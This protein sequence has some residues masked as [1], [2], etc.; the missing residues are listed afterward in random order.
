M[1]SNDKV[2]EL[3]SYFDDLV[4]TL[5]ENESYWRKCFPCKNN[6]N[7]CVESITAA[8]SSEWAIIRE[9][10]SRLPEVDLLTLKRNISNNIRCP[11]RGEN[12]C[13][14][15][16]V[17][18]IVCRV[19]P[20]TIFP[21]SNIIDFSFSSNKCMKTDIYK[22]SAE[23][24]PICLQDDLILL[25]VIP[26]PKKVYFIN[27]NKL[28]SHPICKKLRAEKSRTVFDWLSDYIERDINIP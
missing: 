4:N 7:C 23:F 5:L 14:I 27:G 22:I 24:N 28:F 6:G 21:K 17:R 12:K 20:I 10:I 19:T 3:Y 16:D 26:K 11:F 1:I 18:P 25:P 9:F 8:T 13:I 15:H 2:I